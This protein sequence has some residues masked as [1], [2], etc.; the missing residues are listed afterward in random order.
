[1]AQPPALSLG[2]SVEAS[3]LTRADSWPHLP[4][5]YDPLYVKANSLH[6]I[7]ESGDDSPAPVYLW[8]QPVPEIV[9]RIT[10]RSRVYNCVWNNLRFAY[11][12]VKFTCVYI[13]FSLMKCVRNRNPWKDPRLVY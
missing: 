6:A 1:M 8:I 13:C 9:E 10:K 4:D 11:Y 7:P 2:S 12:S 3:S 5:D